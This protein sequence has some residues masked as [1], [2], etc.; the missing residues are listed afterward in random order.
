[1]WQEAHVTPAKQRQ[2]QVA[3]VFIWL[4][5]SKACRADLQEELHLG[6]PATPDLRQ[7]GDSSAWWHAQC[8]QHGCLCC[9]DHPLSGP[10]ALIRSLRDTP[11]SVQQLSFP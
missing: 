1:M 3:G 2:Q 8:Q 10:A 9:S 11:C 5:C 6:M 7:G 4:L